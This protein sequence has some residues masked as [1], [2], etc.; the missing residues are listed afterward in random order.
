MYT[1]NIAGL[2]QEIWNQFYLFAKQGSRNELISVMPSGFR[3]PLYLRR[4]TS[5]IDNFA[6]IFLR[7]EYNF[8]AFPPASILDLGGY[9]GL[10]S[11]YLAAKYP[12]ASILLVE[13]EH[14]NFLIAQLNCRQFPQ[15][16][17][18]QAGAW[19]KSCNLAITG[20][21]GGD[22]GVTVDEVSDTNESLRQIKAF[23]VSELLAQ[24]G[25]SQLDF[26]KIDI[27]GSE[28]ALFLDPNAA[29]WIKR[30]RLISCELHDRI[31]KGCSEAFHTAMKQQEFTHGK[32]G[33]FEFYINPKM[34]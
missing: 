17:C 21:I 16:K 5:D 33:E 15:I 23:S 8:L 25:V 26:L 14:D 3:S 20:R 12:N 29:E 11:A 19:T 4:S 10:A 31:L 1:L 32:H 30:C 9:I 27:E 13:P 24:M 34:N 6:Q 18:L 22:W 7:K 28:K 2:T